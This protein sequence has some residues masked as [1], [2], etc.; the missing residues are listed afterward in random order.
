MDKA[1]DRVLLRAPPLGLS[2][3]Y[4]H[5]PSSSALAEGMRAAMAGGMIEACRWVFVWVAR[6]LLDRVSVVA[7]F[8]EQDPMFSA[9][10]ETRFVP[11]SD[12]PTDW[13]LYWL[14]RRSAWRTLRK[15][16]A[17]FGSVDSQLK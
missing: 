16:S 14:S 12:A 15:F 6:T 13:L 17:H 10:V 9:S 4:P 1:V 2:L 8:N 7:T 3:I 11:L 5:L